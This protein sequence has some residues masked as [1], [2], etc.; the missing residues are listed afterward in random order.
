MYEIGPLVVIIGYPEGEFP[1]SL[2]E[3]C[4]MPK[5]FGRQSDES[6]QGKSSAALDAIDALYSLEMKANIVAL[7]QQRRSARLH[8]SLAQWSEYWPVAIGIIASFFA[9][10]LREFVDPY[11]PWGL[12]VSFPM[13]ALSIRPEI[14]MGSTLAA[15]LPTAML[16]LQFPL[17]GLLAKFALRGNVSVY[18]VMVQVLYF[19]GLC[20]MQ[21][22]LLNG[23]LWHLMG[24]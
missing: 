3:Q 17:E 20:I 2:P 9:P 7:S 10:Q 16:Y 1:T 5:L 12:W 15:F 14:Q 23:G 11:R 4:A 24:R 22:W 21:L 13:V 18:G 19:H 6:K 8:K